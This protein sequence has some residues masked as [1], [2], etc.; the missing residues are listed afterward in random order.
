MIAVCYA[1]QVLEYPHRI[2]L[3]MFNTAQ[4]Q[5]AIILAVFILL[6]A[7]FVNNMLRFIVA[8][9]TLFLG[10]ISYALYLFHQYLILSFLLPFFITRLH[11]SFL[12]GCIFSLL[13]TVAIASAITIYID[14]PLRFRVRKALQRKFL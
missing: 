8:K 10:R 1:E 2:A 6:F 7:L 5:Y 4:W 9:A 13:I 3:S 11:F 12:V 14:E